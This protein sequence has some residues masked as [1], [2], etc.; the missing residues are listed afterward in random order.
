MSATAPKNQNCSREFAALATDVL[1][2]P[3]G[4]TV[5]C[6]PRASSLRCASLS[7]IRESIAVDQAGGM[8]PF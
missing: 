3:E 1:L 4:P 5:A 7:C 2:V 6:K 8:L